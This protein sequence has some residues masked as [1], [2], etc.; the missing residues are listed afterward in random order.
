METNREEQ[1]STTL[2][3]LVSVGIETELDVQVL[4]SS[5]AINTASLLA[6]L[7][8]QQHRLPEEI[9]ACLRTYGDML[10]TLTLDM[11]THHDDADA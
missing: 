7:L 9:D 10:R 4:L 1:W 6:L 11:I 3:A 5:L 2:D 8:V